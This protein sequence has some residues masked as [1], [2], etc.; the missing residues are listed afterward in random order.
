VGAK[1]RDILG[2][3]KDFGRMKAIMSAKPQLLA[4]KAFAIA[5]WRPNGG[6]PK[7]IVGPAEAGTAQVR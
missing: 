2:F 6:F 4:I 5:D 1:A 7:T 3:V